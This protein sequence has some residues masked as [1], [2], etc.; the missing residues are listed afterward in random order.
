MFADVPM[1]KR[2][3]QWIEWSGSGI[4]LDLASAALSILTVLTYMVST[5]A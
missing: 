4:L 3:N 2:V 5:P 1:A